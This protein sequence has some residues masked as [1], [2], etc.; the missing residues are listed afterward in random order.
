LA[1]LVG[2][3]GLILVHTQN[4]C[5]TDCHCDG[6]CNVEYIYPYPEAFIPNCEA[7]V[8]VWQ[9]SIRSLACFIFFTIDPINFGFNFLVHIIFHLFVDFLLL[10]D[11][12]SLEVIVFII[13]IRHILRLV[14]I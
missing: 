6:S 13:V 5:R 8:F 4:H 10:Y 2:H 9:F 3:G 7:N 11:F 1:L 12:G 14:M